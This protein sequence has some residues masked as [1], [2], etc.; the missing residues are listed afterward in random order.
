MKRIHAIIAMLT[1]VGLGSLFSQNEHN[2]SLTLNA[3]IGNLMRQDLS[4]SPLIHETWSPVNFALIYKKSKKMEQQLY[5]K[6]GSYKPIASEEFNYTSFFTGDEQNVTFPHD[7]A[8]IDLNYSL[9][10]VVV[11]KDKWDLT[12]GGRSK[13]RL[14]PSAYNYG[15]AGLFGYYFSFG[16]DAWVKFEYNL[17][18]KHH[19]E[20]NLSFPLATF[21]ARSPYMS[22]DDEHFENFASHKGLKTI[23]SY[24]QDGAWHYWDKSQHMDL[25][26]SYYYT[27][28]DKWDIGGS[29][30][31]S[32]NFNQD[33]TK[34]ASIENVLYLSVKFKF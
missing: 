22:Q 18:E 34:F 32:M 24:I 19:I 11:T 16:I 26:V 15:T 9:G 25:D 6:F 3:G 5:I 23:A 12:V 10:K 4:F 30:W 29:Y 13:N 28:S 2:S 7:F 20:S 31:L 1:L 33:P 17:Q 21:I 27:L 14:N 8:L